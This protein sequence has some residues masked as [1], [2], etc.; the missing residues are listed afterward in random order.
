MRHDWR[1]VLED[2]IAAQGKRAG[3]RSIAVNYP[4]SLYAVVKDAAKARGMSMTAY[5]RRAALAFAVNDLGLTDDW[6]RLMVDEPPVAS[7]GRPVTTAGFG[8]GPF[9]AWRILGLGMFRR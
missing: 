2:Q 9:G 5:Q 3:R 7:Y 4:T 1:A 8:F 6:A